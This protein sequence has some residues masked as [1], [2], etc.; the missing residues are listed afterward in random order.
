[1]DSSKNTVHVN[2]YGEEYPVRAEGDSEY[3]R[4][5]AHYLDRKMREMAEKVPNRSPSRIAILAALNIADELFQERKKSEDNQVA[6]E[7]RTQEIISL[8]DE[9]LS[10]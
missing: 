1:M 2:I 8:L 4:Q 9:K 3:I 7:A 5:V 6:L 10:V